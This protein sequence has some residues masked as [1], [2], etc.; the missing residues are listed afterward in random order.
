LNGY[1]LP[2]GEFRPTFHVQCRFAVRPVSDELPHFKAMPA[3]FGG[4]DE[5][6]E[7]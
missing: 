4:S 6:V 1:L 2:Q 5:V 3:R 7:W